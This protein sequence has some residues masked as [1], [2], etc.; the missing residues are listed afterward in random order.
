[1]YGENIHII[2]GNEASFHHVVKILLNFGTY[3]N[4]MISFES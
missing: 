2:Y 4:Y 3:L 1:M